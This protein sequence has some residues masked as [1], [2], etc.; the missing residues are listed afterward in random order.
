MELVNKEYLATKLKKEHS[1]SLGIIKQLVQLIDLEIRHQE[2]GDPELKSEFCLSD[3]EQHVV[4]GLNKLIGSQ[5]TTIETDHYLCVMSRVFQELGFSNG[6]VRSIDAPITAPLPL[7]DEPQ[8]YPHGSTLKIL[9]EDGITVGYAHDGGDGK[10]LSSYGRRE[11][12]RDE[13]SII[14]TCSEFKP[15]HLDFGMHV[16]TTEPDGDSNY[17]TAFTGIVTEIHPRSVCLFTGNAHYDVKYSEIARINLMNAVKM[18][19]Q[20]LM[21]HLKPGMSVDVNSPEHAD[22]PHSEKFTGKVTEVFPGYAE[23]LHPEGHKIDIV[24]DEIVSFRL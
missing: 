18:A 11:L 12:K 1:D 10:L 6:N 5:E 17:E 16:K 13:W 7:L 21:R 14:E 3:F 2:G 15:E 9:H 22:A 4:G 24:F 8:A 23:V 19:D 20:L